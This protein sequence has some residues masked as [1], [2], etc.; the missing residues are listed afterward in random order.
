MGRFSCWLSSLRDLDRQR[1][2]AEILIL[3]LREL[4]VAGAAGSAAVKWLMDGLRYLVLRQLIQ[5]E[6]RSR[7]Y[8]ARTVAHI[9]DPKDIDACLGLQRRYDCDFQSR[10][11][12]WML[13][14]PSGIVQ[15]HAEEVVVQIFVYSSAC[16]FETRSE[17]AIRQNC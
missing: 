9:C 16:D 12:L 10:G 1:S 8:S 17:A 15:S 2:R 4:D 13:I 5:A 7:C 14:L 11:Q 3:L 6:C